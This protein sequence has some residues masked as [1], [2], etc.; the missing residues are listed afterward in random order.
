MGSGS[1]EGRSSFAL[2]GNFQRV[3]D[4]RVENSLI[5]YA[6]LKKARA[7]RGRMVGD[8]AAV[9]SVGRCGR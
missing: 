8:I 2:L 9:V 5:S 4:M 3:E 6:F 1:A 7:Q